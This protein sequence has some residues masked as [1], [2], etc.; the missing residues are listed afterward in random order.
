[1]CA[2]FRFPPRPQAKAGQDSFVSSSVVVGSAP[3]QWQNPKKKNKQQRIDGR[4]HFSEDDD[5]ANVVE[6]PSH[7]RRN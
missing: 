4:R 5:D 2:V 6:W 1:M 3:R 7:T